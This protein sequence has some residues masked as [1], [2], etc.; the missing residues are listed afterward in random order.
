MVKHSP[1]VAEI[2]ETSRQV[3]NFPGNAAFCVLAKSAKVE[4][5]D[6]QDR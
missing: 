6:G 5:R 1:R 4:L 3:P 2:I